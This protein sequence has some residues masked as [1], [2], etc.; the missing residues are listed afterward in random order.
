MI[1]VSNCCEEDEKPPISNGLA[2]MMVFEKGVGLPVDAEYEDP[3][4]QRIA[5]RMQAARDEFRAATN[6]LIKRYNLSLD[7]DDIIKAEPQSSEPEY[8]HICNEKLRPHGVGHWYCP[9]W[10]DTHLEEAEEP[11]FREAAEVKPLKVKE[12]ADGIAFCVCER[13]ECNKWFAD[14]CC[15]CGTML[16]EEH[17][18]CGCCGHTPAISDRQI[19]EEFQLEDVYGDE[20]NEEQAVQEVQYV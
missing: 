4:T 19:T 11:P 7:A 6:E 18:A 10:S 2:F 5:Q 9:C 15:L 1:V 3:A 13:R 8:C 14:S 17:M 20:A 16:C 12:D